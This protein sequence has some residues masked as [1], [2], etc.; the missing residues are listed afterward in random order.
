MSLFCKRTDKTKYNYVLQALFIKK[1]FFPMHLSQLI[2]DILDFIRVGSVELQGTLG[3][4]E[5]AK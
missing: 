3:N 2:N 4:Q 5:N 1:G